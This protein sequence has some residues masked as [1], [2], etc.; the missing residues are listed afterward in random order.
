M[1]NKKKV[2]GFKNTKND[3]I[4]TPYPITRA[5]IDNYYFKKMG[6]IADFTCGYGH[7]LK[8]FEDS[9]HYFHWQ[10]DGSDIRKLNPKYK[11]LDIF[12]IT[13]IDGL[14]YLV[15][16]PPY[17]LKLQIVEHI[18]KH[19][20]VNH[21]VCLLL[22]STC[23][24][25]LKMNEYQKYITG[26]INFDRQL[27]LSKDYGGEYL[28][29]GGMSH[30]S[31]FIFDVNS[32]NYGVD[33]KVDF[34]KTQKTADWKFLTPTEAKNYLINRDEINPIREKKGQLLLGV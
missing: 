28:V 22:P 10:I 19:I 13:G 5:L 31:W 18:F 25:Q 3:N 33:D 26:I 12:D 9:S 1:S 14:D 16:N 27:N 17:S 2:K 24:Q 11:V 4:Y 15:M 20:H 7:I 30:Y 29:K 23:F 32:D 8:V 21:A 34:I 6:H